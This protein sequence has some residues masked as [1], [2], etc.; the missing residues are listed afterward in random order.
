MPTLME[1]VGRERLGKYASFFE[2][3]NA[4]WQD[5]KEYED[6]QSYKKIA[7]ERIKSVFGPGW[8]LVSFTKRPFKIVFQNNQITGYFKATRNAIEYGTMP[9]IPKKG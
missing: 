3:L 6:F 4:R 9:H 2:Y 7:E 8:V 5:E 1:T